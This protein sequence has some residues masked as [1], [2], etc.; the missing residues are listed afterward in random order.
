MALNFNQLALQS[1][2]AADGGLPVG[3]ARSSRVVAGA[4]L[5]N[6]YELGSDTSFLLVAESL[7]S[8]PSINLLD[9]G[10]ERHTWVPGAAGEIYAF[11]DVPILVSAI[12]AGSVIGSVRIILL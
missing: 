3:P 8:T 4:D 9:G 5:V 1:R 12:L 6:G 10:R 11:A 2:L 7:G